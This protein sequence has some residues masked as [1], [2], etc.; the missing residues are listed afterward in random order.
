MGDFERS[1][2]NFIQRTEADVPAAGLT[3]SHDDPRIEAYLRADVRIGSDVVTSEPELEEVSSWIAQPRQYPGTGV[4]LDVTTIVTLRELLEGGQ[5]SP[6]TLWDLSRAVTAI[7]CYDNVFHFQ[8]SEVDDT[9]LNALLGESAFRALKVPTRDPS[10]EFGGGGGVAGLFYNAWNE[11]DTLMRRLEAS[12][13]LDTLEGGAVED[14]TRQWSL[15]LGHELSPHDVIN[16]TES[17]YEW[18]SPGPGLLEEL[19]A[20]GNSGD[21]LDRQL[22]QAETFSSEAPELAVYVRRMSRRLIRE[23]NYRGHVNERLARHLQLPY[24]PNTARLPFRGLFYDQARLISD[25]LPS[26]IALDDYY[27]E[28]ASQAK[29]LC[30][31]PFL[32]PVF[33]A[34]VLRRA[35]RP[36]DLWAAVAQVRGNAAAY[37]KR[38]EE[39]DGAL[40]RGDLDVTKATLGAVR[41]EASKLTTLLLDASKAA[42]NAALTSIETDPVSSIAATPLDWVLRGVTF[43]IAGARKLVPPSVAQRLAWRMCRPEFR[44]LSDVGSESRAITDSFPAIRKIWGVPDST[45]AEFIRRYQSVGS[46]PSLGR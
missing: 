7:G 6:V 9:R 38:R 5:L 12:I 46:L 21:D 43:L 42:G 41:T 28:R 32:L 29:L 34:L 16:V 4:L 20:S 22:E 44:F 39:L 19:L 17:D 11:T 30:G 23:S 33:L 37:R 2:E 40:E 13:G 36:Q 14:L 27:F 35:T 15:T 1:W 8:N 24:M 31:D 3:L 26:V 18:P 45:A 10:Y 25:R